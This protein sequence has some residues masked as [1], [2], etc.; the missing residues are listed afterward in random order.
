MFD[1]ISGKLVYKS[2]KYIVLDVN[3]IGFRIL[4]S[5][6]TYYKLP[7]INEIAKLFIYF[8]L[9]EN[10]SLL[11]GFGTNKEKETFEILISVRGVGPRLAINV[12]SELSVEEFKSAIIKNDLET[13]IGIPGIGK[14]MVQRI[15]LELKEKVLLITGEEIEVSDRKEL[16]DDAILALVSLGYTQN[17]ST[18]AVKK[19]LESTKEEVSLEILIKQAIREFKR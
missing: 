18:S 14:K 6:S 4:I 5:L 3:G 1:Y 7:E 13:L 8:Y 15:L 17:S 10:M 16:I 2:P 12:L 11:Y 19:V 9:R